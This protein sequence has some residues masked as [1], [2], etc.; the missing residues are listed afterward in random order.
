M[1]QKLFVHPS[2]QKPLLLLW[3]FFPHARDLTCG[4]CAPAYNVAVA[5]SN[6]RHGRRDDKRLV[7]TDQMASFKQM[8]ITAIMP[9]PKN[10]A[11]LVLRHEWG[12]L[13]H[14]HLAGAM[15]QILLE[16]CQ[17]LAQADKTHQLWTAC[18]KR[19]IVMEK[20]AMPFRTIS[21]MGPPCGNTYTRRA[22]CDM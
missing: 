7:T 18:L 12:L 9:L 4:L 6:G 2:G 20:Q 5:L 3:L 17:K 14:H 10:L 8:I 15:V 22:Q 11:K 21:Q 13:Q 1:C 19:R 16:R